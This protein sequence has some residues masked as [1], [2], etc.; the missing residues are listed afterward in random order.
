MPLIRAAA[1]AAVLC[2]AAPAWSQDLTL[3]QADAAYVRGDYAAAERAYLALRD[4]SGRRSGTN[5]VE[6]A[7]LLAKQANVYREEERFDLGVPMAEWAVSIMNGLLGFDDR[8]SA[9]AY[10]TLATMYRV[11]GRDAEKQ[12]SGRADGF[13][14]QSLKLVERTRGADIDDIAALLFIYST[15]FH[16]NA[17]DVEGDDLDDRLRALGYGAG[18]L[19][20]TTRR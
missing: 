1:I 19:T 4:A 12:F 9:F 5:T 20:H 7:T 10:A 14:W 16:E 3:A 17:R 15:V 2:I 11:Q 13:M 18:R 8:G 6:Y